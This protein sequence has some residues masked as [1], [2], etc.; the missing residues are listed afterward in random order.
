MPV[1]L[2]YLFKNPPTGDEVG[3]KFRLD[4]DDTYGGRV[5]Q[6]T[7]DDPND[8]SFGFVVLASPE[9]IQ[10]S[11]DKR[12]G[13]HWDVFGCN[14][15]V[16]EGEHTVQMVCT[17]DSEMSNC[18]KIGLGRGV[19]GTILEMPEGCG[20]GRYAVAKDMKPSEN[21]TV[22]AH[23]AKRSKIA[24]PLVF[25]LT[26]DYDFTRVPRDLGD[27]QIRIDYSNEEGYW[28]EIVN[29]A[30]E[31]RKA[32]RSL[33][34]SMVELVRLDVLLYMPS[35]PCANECLPSRTSEAIIDVGSKMHGAKITRAVSCPGLSSTNAGLAVISS[36]GS[37]DSSAW[38]IK[39]R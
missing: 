17:D 36:P 20:P 18:Y 15:A 7:Q 24:N 39:R 10:V 38:L 25:D 21:Q 27:T 9:A 30:G 3:V 12:D 34:V 32:K 33:E 2:D 13:S 11:V 6:G 26:F 22:P 23:V 16:T 14:D 5:T 4:V 8:A 1:P 31:K 37:R 29:K 28:N 35:L 19:P